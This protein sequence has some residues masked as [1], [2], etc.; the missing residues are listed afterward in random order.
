MDH[1]ADPVG[2]KYVSRAYQGQFYA[3]LTQ[4]EGIS[5]AKYKIL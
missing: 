2:F 1:D 5:A 4:N 3:C